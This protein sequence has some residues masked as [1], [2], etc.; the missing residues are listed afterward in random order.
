MHAGRFETTHWSL[1]LGA[2]EQDAEA[3]GALAVLCARYRPPVLAYVR[4]HAGLHEAEDLVQAFF[5]RVLDARLYD[6]ADPTRGRFRNFLLTALQNFLHHQHEAGQRLKRG[7]GVTVSLEPEALERLAGG[8]GPES[9]FDR[10]WALAALDGA[11]TRLRRECERAGRGAWFRALEPYVLEPVERDGYHAL[12]ERMGSK[13][14]TIAVAVG[15]L[16]QRLRE[17]VRAEL[18]ETVH[19]ER[20]L[21]DELHALRDALA[22]ATRS[23]A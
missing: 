4:R 21:G 3:R 20:D 2:G 1:V 13:P 22:H 7:A 6:R 5:E 12:A 17:H 18:S 16:R 19:S 15:R 8:D 10:A 9:E 14:N 23:R 11:L